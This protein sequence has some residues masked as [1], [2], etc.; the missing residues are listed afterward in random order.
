MLSVFLNAFLGV[1]YLA[2]GAVIL[3]VGFG[4]LAFIGFGLGV[5]KFGWDMLAEGG[6]I[7]AGEWNG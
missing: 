4:L 3:A 2:S 6:R 5:V 1:F 7:L